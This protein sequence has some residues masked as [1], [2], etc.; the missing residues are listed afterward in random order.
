MEAMADAMSYFRWRHGLQHGRPVKIF[1]GKLTFTKCL[2]WS[3]GIHAGCTIAFRVGAF[4]RLC[5]EPE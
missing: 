1:P 2:L 5:L 3:G 4:K